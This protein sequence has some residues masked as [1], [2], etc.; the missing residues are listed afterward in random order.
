[1]MKY[2]NIDQKLVEQF[3]NN[4]DVHVRAEEPMNCQ[5]LYKTLDACIQAVLTDENADA[6]QLIKQANSDFQRNYLDKIS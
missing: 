5:E 3:A 4:T 6:E 2:A 1:M